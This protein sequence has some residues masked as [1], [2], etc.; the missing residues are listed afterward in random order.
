MFALQLIRKLLKLW[1]TLSPG[2]YNISGIML[3]DR[4]AKSINLMKW[5]DMQ[6]LACLYFDILLGF[7]FTS[8]FL[9]LNS[10]HLSYCCLGL[11]YKNQRASLVAEIVKNP[12]A[13]WETWVQSLSWENP[14]PNSGIE[15]TFP[16]LQADV[17]MYSCLENPHGQ[18]SL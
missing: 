1:L 10:F 2:W 17:G 6:C 3:S 7:K 5:D 12:P 4:L 16:T 11:C 18:R 14:L 13:M 15:P 8:I 9:F